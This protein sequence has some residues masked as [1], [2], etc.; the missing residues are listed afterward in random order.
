MS[1][2]AQ[3]TLEQDSFA[4]SMHVQIEQILVPGNKKA[5][6]LARWRLR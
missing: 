6:R 5:A 1:S 2:H 4:K 3:L